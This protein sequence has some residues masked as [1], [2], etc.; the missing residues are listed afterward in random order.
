MF[1]GETGEE[2]QFY[3]IVMKE[4]E[5]KH[6]LNYVLKEDGT[7]RSHINAHTQ[8]RKGVSFQHVSKIE[9]REGLAH[10]D[11]QKKEEVEKDIKQPNEVL[12]E[13]ERKSIEYFLSHVEDLE[14]QEDLM[15]ESSNETIMS[16]GSKTDKLCVI[17]GI[18]ENKPSYG[19]ILG[20]AKIF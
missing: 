2:R 11:G 17:A 20:E 18:A 4:E 12:E 8:L 14:Q 5:D 9:G 13:A 1:A 6:N 16:C 19:T 3:D 15:I 7:A 10:D